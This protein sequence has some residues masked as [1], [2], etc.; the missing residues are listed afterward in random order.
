[1]RKIN[2][3]SRIVFRYNNAVDKRSDIRTIARERASA[4]FL[5]GGGNNSG[6]TRERVLNR[7]VELTGR[8]RYRENRKISGSPPDLDDPTLSKYS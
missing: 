3:P 5:N 1:L 6:L 8:I 4:R 7:E 2:R